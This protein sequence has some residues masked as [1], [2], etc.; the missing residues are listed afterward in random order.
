VPV[1]E[2]MRRLGYGL[3][4]VEEQADPDPEFSNTKNP[5]PEDK[6]AFELAVAKA[7]ACRADIVITTDPDADR[8]GV[9]VLHSGQYEF[10]SGNQS[11]AVLLNYI[12]SRRQEQGTLPQNGI[13]INTIVT[14]D[15]GD[16]IARDYGM[17]VEKTLTGFKF[18]GDRIRAYEQTG[19]YAYVF[20][21][22]ESY[23]YLISPIARDKD[24]IQAVLM[25]CEA[26]AYYKARGQTLKDV[27]DGLFKRY[28]YFIE[29]QLAVTLEGAAGTAHIAGIMSM[30][31]AQPPMELAG[32]KV[33]ACEDYES[34]FRLSGGIKSDLTLPKSDVLK[35]I[36]E[37]GSWAAIR[38]SGTEPKCK[39][40]LC[41]QGSSMAE[42]EA[43]LEG[44]KDYFK[45]FK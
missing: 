39:F 3:V 10:L 40:Y 4:V 42:A 14:S 17:A 27:L 21:Y 44:M 30:L 28:G 29:G 43:T 23:G 1:R 38:P 16:R 6:A 32:L 35:F 9:A 19:K 20:G 12:L 5:N 22:E 31:R 24:A 34:G 41:A 33:A 7:E 37:D 26:A 2:I 15:L 11:G 25:I 45:Q 13:V 36:L 18:I 8:L